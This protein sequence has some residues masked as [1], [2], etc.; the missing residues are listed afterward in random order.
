MTGG[1]THHSLLSDFDASKGGTVVPQLSPHFHSREFAC[2][3][4]GQ[5]GEISAR[6]LGVLETARR[7]AGNR[8]LRLVS[9][10]RCVPFNRR[11]GGH[12]TSEHLFGR[13]VDVP[14]GYLT[15]AQW[16]AAGAV[17]VGVRRGRVV[18]IDVRPGSRPVVFDD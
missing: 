9:G 18:H 1:V 6:L 13:A 12:P 14:G 16:I 10:R 17:G 5:V 2:P 7:A 4:C 3:D 15:S 8:P 11:V